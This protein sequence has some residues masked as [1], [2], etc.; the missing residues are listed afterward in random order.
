TL[1]LFTNRYDAW[2]TSLATR[3]L[4]DL[5]EAGAGVHL[6]A[7]GWLVDLQDA[8]PV[9][10]SADHVHAPSPSHAATAAVLRHAD[11]DDR[12]VSVASSARRFDVTSASVRIAR[13]VVEAVAEGRPLGSVLGYRIERFLQDSDQS[14]HIEALRRGYGALGGEPPDPTVAAEVVSAHDV[15][16]G[17]AV[18]RAVADPA[19]DRAAHPPDGDIPDPRTIDGL[20]E[21]LA[22]L[23]DSLADLLVAEGVHQLVTGDRSRA[24]A[25]ITALAR[26]VPPPRELH[27][28]DTPGR[29]LAVPV[30]LL[31]AVKPGAAPTGRGWATK[32]PRAR[33][34][35]AAER[36]ARS[37]LPDPGD[38]GLRLE[39][40][41]ES[42]DGPA[43]TEVV[44]VTLDDLGLC[45]LDV[46]AEVGADDEHS[47]LATRVRHHLGRAGKLL[48]E[49]ADGADV[50]WAA[51]T[52]VAR[53]WARVFGT[54]R[55]LLPGDL[56]LGPKEGEEPEDP[57]SAD[58]ASAALDV[59][60]EVVAEL[61]EAG[62]ALQQR[63]DS[64]GADEPDDAFAQD[65]APHLETFRVAGLAGTAQEPGEDAAS[66]GLVGLVRRCAAAGVAADQRL[67][68][69]TSTPETDH[70]VLAQRPGLGVRDANE[71]TE[72]LAAAAREI[73]GEPVVVAPAVDAGRLDLNATD[74]LRA[75]DDLVDWLGELSEVRTGTRRWWQA[76]LATEALTGRAPGL[77]PSQ[78]PRPDGEGWIGGW[79][80]EPSGWQPPFGARRAFVTHLPD[81]E[82][83]G[84]VSALVV[85]SWVEEVPVGFEHDPHRT[86]AQEEPHVPHLETTGVAVHFNG[87][88]ARPPQSILLAVPPDPTVATWHLGDLVATLLETI[89]LSRFRGV[90]PPEDLP[91][92]SVVPAVFVPEGIEGLSFVQLLFDLV[93]AQQ[94]SSAAVQHYRRFGDA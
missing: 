87:A 6:G 42:D 22:F 94:L 56:A 8:E 80:G 43:T 21:H 10:P 1:D 27:V 13:G 37:V 31:M 71:L 59:L 18:W 51:L 20:V 78:F 39:A 19:D 54:A 66:P 88:G 3:R 49:P 41:V 55:P 26:G 72:R 82:P 50:G 15:V 48:P 68:Q 81:D 25:T 33:I 4:G 45:A 34:A 76:V 53:S 92:R 62:Q 5:R 70:P 46:L 79:V 44:T 67:Q 52:A 63:L 89:E 91:S 60:V 84:S 77:V 69:L 36:L 38:C 85:E 65:V 64:L 57:P 40:V 61:V 86:P 24:G 32:S 16:D 30:L 93:S 28:V 35:P 75:G 23:V 29:H 9:Q 14:Q 11:I 17:V 83:G 7:F 74:G 2:V 73:F 58:A 12:A 47:S 90:E